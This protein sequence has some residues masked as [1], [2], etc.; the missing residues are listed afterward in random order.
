MAGEIKQAIQAGE[1]WLA[2]FP[3][4]FGIN[5]R[6]GELHCKLGDYKAGF[7]CLQK[8]ISTNPSYDQDWKSTMIV[9]LGTTLYG[10]LNLEKRIKNL[11]LPEEVKLVNELI[12]NYWP[13]FGKLSQDSQRWWT[14]GVF[15]LF[16][17]K[18][19]AQLR[20][21]VPDLAGFS[22]GKSV[23][24]ELG[25]KIFGQFRDFVRSRDSLMQAARNQMSLRTL[26]GNFCSYLA[27]EGAHLGLGGML[28]LLKH[29][30]ARRDQD[31]LMVEFD[32]WIRGHRA[33][34]TRLV[35][36]RDWSELR[37]SVSTRNRA[38]HRQAT[39]DDVI[40]LHS[41]AKQLLEATI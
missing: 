22:F 30:L 20:T 32:R 8:E 29:A 6:L 2:E 39:M 10:A 14:N 31:Q 34:L 16:S 40:V 9:E 33:Q 1:N 19:A 13:S 37:E 3:E 26:S 12:A 38:V 4:A 24:I 36:A 15:F 21:S 28:D 25:E 11:V 5:E 35:G 7:D 18:L 23:E 27:G 41:A 17:M